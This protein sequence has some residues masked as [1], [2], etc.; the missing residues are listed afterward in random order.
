M[1]NCSF[2]LRNSNEI[3]Q[4]VCFC[5]ELLRHVFHML[6]SPS[7]SARVPI[8]NLILDPNFNSSHPLHPLAWPW[9]C[10]LGESFSSSTWHFSN[11]LPEHPAPV[12]FAYTARLSTMDT[13]VLANTTCIL[14]HSASK[15]MR[16]QKE[17]HQWQ[18]THEQNLA[19]FYR[20]Q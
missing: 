4:H 14:R 20:A 1:T 18:R 8:P 11:H 3:R 19:A 10:R 15:S 17:R 12:S 2:V 5:Y 13:F 16:S 9:A 6:T 7:I